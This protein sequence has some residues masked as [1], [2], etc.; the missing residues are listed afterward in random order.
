MY[1][2]CPSWATPSV[3]TPRSVDFEVVDVEGRRLT[4]GDGFALL[5]L[6]LTTLNIK[7]F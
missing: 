5:L 3:S 7:R 2:P 1:T 4:E 6:P